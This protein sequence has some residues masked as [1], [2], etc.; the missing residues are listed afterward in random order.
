MDQPTELLS[1]LDQVGRAAL[2]GASS[3]HVTQGAQAFLDAVQPGQLR[4]ADPQM[5]PVVEQL[6]ELDLTVTAES[7]G[8]LARSLRWVPSPRGD[9]TEGRQIALAPLND[10]IDLGPVVAGLMAVGAD[11]VYPEHNHSPQELYLTLSGTGSWRYG[12][13]EHYEPVGPGTTFYNPPRVTHSAR[14]SNDEPLLA[15]YI[16]WPEPG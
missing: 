15:L 6:L 10:H 8:P 12:G 16:L 5:V 11:C 3:T 7:F 2:D 1:F 4:D 9:D 13:N 14:A